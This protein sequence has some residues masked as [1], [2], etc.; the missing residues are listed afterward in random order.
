[1]RG[2][3]DSKPSELMDNKPCFLFRQLFMQ[4]L[5]DNVRASLANSTCTDYRALAQEADKLFIATQQHHYSSTNH[6]RFTAQSD[7]IEETGKRQSGPT[8]A[9][10]SAGPRDP[11]L[12]ITDDN[13][14]RCF[15]VDTGAQV[16]VIP[17]TPFDKNAGPSGLPLHAANGTPIQ[18]YGSRNLQLSFNNRLYL[19]KIIIANVKRPLLGADFFRNHNLLVDL[20]GKR[21]IEADTFLT[22]PCSVGKS[23]VTQ[24]A[25]IEAHSNRF[26][27]ILQEFPSILQP[28]FSSAAVKHGVQHFIP[29]S[30]PPIHA[31]ARRLHPD[32]L[33]VAKREFLQME[34]MGIIRKS[35]SPW[36]SPLHIVPKENGGWRPCGDYRRLNDATTPDRYPIPH[37]HDFSSQLEGKTIFSKIDLVR[38][39]HQI[40][41]NPEDIPKTAIITPFDGYSYLLT[42]IDRTTRWP[43]A[44]PINNT[45]TTECA[46][47]LIRH[48]ISRFGVPVDMTSDRG[49]Q[50]TSAL[51]TAIAEKLGTNIHHTCAYHPQSNGLVERFHRS[52]KAALK[53]RLQGAN[54]V[55]ELPWVLL[56]LRTVP[57]EDLETSSELVY[58]EPLTVPAEKL[59]TN[60][61]H[62]CAYHPQSNGLVERFH[63]SLKAALKARLQGANW[64]DEL[65]WVLLGLRTVPKE[66]LETSSAELV[67]GEPL[68]VPGDF[69]HKDAHQSPVPNIP[70]QTI[71]QKIAPPPM[72]HHGYLPPN[73]SPTL[74]DSHFVFIRRDGHRGPLQR[75]Y[76]GPFREITPGDKTF[77]VIVGGR[78]ELIS[79]DRLKPAHVDLTNPVPV[80]LP[81]RRGRPPQVTLNPQQTTTSPPTPVE[82]EPQSTRHSDTG[83][84]VS[85]SGRSVQPPLRFQDY[86][87]GA[88]GSCVATTKPSSALTYRHSYRCRV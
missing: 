36:A 13:S 19:A 45:S 6:E 85:R 60:I 7:E 53:A 58:G 79:V 29:T 75:P 39:Y 41:M 22:S 71:L 83:I 88:G 4:Q 74:K 50:F 70:F 82:F 86:D 14:G 1:M 47:T 61:H 40:P 84:R 64:V 34:E 76:D 55:D 69:F 87:V 66:D 11:Q 27:K 52:L 17:A 46:K 12:F 54:W 43:E 44:I 25:P 51:W 77:L 26:R 9:S 30:G 73:L 81:P 28:T 49:P 15:L 42:I 72:L 21:L 38:G 10:A 31:H 56:G 20:R 2:L 68:T 67:Y 59:G 32:K 62:T 16:S 63:R 80:A 37:I 78:E 18:T 3:S 57:K 33:V 35:S 48:W 65:P 24:L 23:A 8:V 5:P